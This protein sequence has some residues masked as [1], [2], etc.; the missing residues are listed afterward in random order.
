MVSV[1]LTIFFQSAEFLREIKMLLGPKYDWLFDM[2]LADLPELSI[3]VSP[4]IADLYV[5]T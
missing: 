1:N 2:L 3:P 5:T 4:F